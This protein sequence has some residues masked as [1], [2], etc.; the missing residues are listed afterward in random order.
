MW[1]ETTG[2]G[3]SVLIPPPTG[4]TSVGATAEWIVEG[5][6][7]DLPNFELVVFKNCW[8]AAVGNAIDL[9]HPIST[10]IKGNSGPLTATEAVKST[11]C[12]LVVCNGMD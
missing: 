9:S 3:T 4:V 6:S 1:N 5:I 8:A 12:V 10:N 7:A 11:K 2:A